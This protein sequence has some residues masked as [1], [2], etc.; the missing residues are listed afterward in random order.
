MIVRGSG[1]PR[2]ASRTEAE[3]RSA[4]GSRAGAKDPN[5]RCGRSSFSLFPV[6]FACE[7]VYRN[8]RVNMSIEFRP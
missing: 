6:N 8:S 3:R 4:R 7:F 2:L 1:Q 5:A